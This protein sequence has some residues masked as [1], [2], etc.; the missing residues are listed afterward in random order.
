MPSCSTAR[1]AC[2][3][4]PP[5]GCGCKLD[6]A[7]LRDVGRRD[8]V[9]QGRGLSHRRSTPAVAAAAALPAGSTAEQADRPAA[10]LRDGSRTSGG[11]LDFEDVLLATAGMIEPEPAVADA[12][13]RA[14][15]LLRRRR[16]PGR[17][18][19]AAPPAAASGSATAATSASSATP[20]RPSTPS[21]ARA[22]TTCSSSRAGYPDADG[23]AARAELPLDADRSSTPPTG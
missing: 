3:P 2:S 5:S 22:P 23:G 10:G 7:T 13:A 19:A 1:R 8:R 6:T 18:A 12:G 11:Q 20:A 17:L 14:V 21:P 4:T 9:A 15:P 16:V